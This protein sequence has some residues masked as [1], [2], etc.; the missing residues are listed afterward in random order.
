METDNLTIFLHGG[1]V[2]DI[3]T[4]GEP[5]RVTVVDSDTDGIDPTDLVELHDGD[6][7]VYSPSVSRLT[8]DAPADVL[9]LVEGLY[10]EGG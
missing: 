1:L 7:L 10:G 4:D 6:Y 8:S 3:W 2:Q 9:R 5:V